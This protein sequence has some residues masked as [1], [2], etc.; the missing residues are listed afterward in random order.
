MNEK[1]I[2]LKAVGIRWR[3]AVDAWERARERCAEQSLSA[4]N[5]GIPYVE[6]LPDKRERDRVQY[7]RSKYRVSGGG[8]PASIEDVRAALRRALLSETVKDET[9]ADMHA[10]WRETGNPGRTKISK[11]C[12]VTPD[13]VTGVLGAARRTY[14]DVPAS[15]RER[16]LAQVSAA[17][18]AA[19]RAARAYR[20]AIETRGHAFADHREAGE[21]VSAIAGVLG[22]SCHTVISPAAKWG[23]TESPDPRTLTEIH[24]QVVNAR[25][26]RKLT[27]DLRLR[28]LKA[29]DGQFPRKVIAEAAGMSPGMVTKLL[30]SAKRHG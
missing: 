1:E 24:Q 4:H 16:I 19:A 20:E 13:A 3:Q 15:D 11:L 29:A 8:A 18:A 21:T 6:M 12:G 5:A 22:L 7:W 9:R 14:P 10:A 26:A 30:H 17:S 23:A 25:V 28:A 2:R 27:Y